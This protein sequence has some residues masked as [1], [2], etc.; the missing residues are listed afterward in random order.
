MNN[1]GVWIFFCYEYSK[2]G[3]HT[4]NDTNFVIFMMYLCDGTLGM[5]NI[6]HMEIFD[7]LCCSTTICPIC[8]LQE[9]K[10]SSTQKYREED[11][12][13]IKSKNRKIK[14]RTQKKHIR[15]ICKKCYPNNHTRSNRMSTNIRIMKWC[16]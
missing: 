1:N 8:S 3:N 13:D 16:S 11:I 2:K 9:E 12:L 14:P 15:E 7:G 4:G 6:L 5:K 10:Y